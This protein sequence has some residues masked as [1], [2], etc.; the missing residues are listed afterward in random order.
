MAS[1]LGTIL[2]LFFIFIAFIFGVDFVMIQLTYTTLDSLSTSVSYRIS[3]TGEISDSLKSDILKNDS[4]ILEAIGNDHAYEEGAILSY[5]LIKEY[6]LISY[7]APPIPIKVK[8]YAIVNI[9]G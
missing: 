5:Y 2:S 3:K 7:E 1:K 6:K 4:V 8:R 9:Y